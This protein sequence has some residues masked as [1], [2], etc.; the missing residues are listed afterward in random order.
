VAATL[1]GEITEAQRKAWSAG[2]VRLQL[3][4]A[5]VRLAR[6]LNGVFG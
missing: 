4:K 6:V 3:E 1:K 5:G 2:A